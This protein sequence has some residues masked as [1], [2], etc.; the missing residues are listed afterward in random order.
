[1]AQFGRKSFS[2]LGKQKIFV[3]CPL[4]RWGSKKFLFA[5]RFCVGERKYICSLLAFADGQAKNLSLLL[6]FVFG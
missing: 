4:L 2:R 6:G 3:F 5:A 1:M